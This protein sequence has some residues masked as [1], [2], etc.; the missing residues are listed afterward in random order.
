M[1]SIQITTAGRIRMKFDQVP[2][3]PTGMGCVKGV[4]GA[5]PASG[6][7]VGNKL[8]KTKVAGRP[9]S[10]HRMTW[11][12]VLL[13][14]W[15]LTM[16]GVYKIKVVEKHLTAIWLGTSYPDPG[17]R[18]GPKGGPVDLW[19]LEGQCLAILTY[20]SHHTKP[21]HFNTIFKTSFESS[22][23]TPSHPG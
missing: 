14:P 10:G 11:P 23:E 18:G 6:L 19:I 1:F 3:N 15:S 16:K 2:P 22:R 9:K 21:H 5:S 12:H 4:R 17:V 13:Q 20:F 7:H 8:Y